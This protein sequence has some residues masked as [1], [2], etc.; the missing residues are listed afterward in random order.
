MDYIK[1]DRLTRQ[2]FAAPDK[3]AFLAEVWSDLNAAD[4][5]ALI[6]SINAEENT[7]PAGR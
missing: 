6:D 2:Y 5:R 7:A 4:G 3:A 1:I